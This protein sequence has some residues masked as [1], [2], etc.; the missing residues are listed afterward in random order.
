V[1]LVGK[2]DRLPRPSIA[3]AVILAASITGSGR[4][5][6]AT[7]DDRWPAWSPDG[8]RVVFT[9]TRTGDPE[10]FVLT[11]DGRSAPQQLTRTPGR[12]AHPAFSPDGRK[13]VFQSPREAGGHTNLYLMNADGSNQQRITRHTGFAGAP[14]W[15]PDGKHIAYQW[16]PELSKSTWR[17]MLLS[18][19]PGAQP[20]PLTDGS[21][22]D[23]VINWARDGQRFV[24]YSDR[25]GVDQLYTMTLGGAVARLTRSGAADRSAAWSPDGRSIAFM[26][27]R[28]GVPAGVYVMSADGTGVRRVGALTPGHGVPFFSPDGTR[29]LTTRP[30]ANG[31]E[32]VALRV[33]DGGVEV[34]S[35]C[36]DGSG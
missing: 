16:T 30:G 21:A 32:I 3:C 28:D 20:R 10:I 36:G 19:E 2:E 24:F 4:T 26:S 7:C 25:T 18:T 22:N 14:V 5:G 12:D 29:V 1:S 34:L 33:T 8:G 17:L 35:R 9:S 23:Q 27:E 31:T 13:I 11:I 6:L 15:S